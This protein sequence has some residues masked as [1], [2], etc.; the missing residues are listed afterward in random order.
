MD[1]RD[2]QGNAGMIE[3]LGSH[4]TID[5]AKTHAE[6]HALRTNPNGNLHW[7]QFSPTTWGLMDGQ[8]YTYILISWIE[9]S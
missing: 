1:H 8:L 3:D 7:R 9:A 4:P 5:T 2:A 6:A